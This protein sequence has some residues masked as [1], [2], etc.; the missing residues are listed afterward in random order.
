[1]PPRKNRTRVGESRHVVGYAGDRKCV[2]GKDDYN[3]KVSYTHGMTRRDAER[4]LRKK[5]G[6][7]DVDRLIF[8]LV[9]VAVMK[10]RCDRFTELPRPKRRGKEGNGK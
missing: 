3:G 4:Y 5:L 1:M 2:Y 10:A 6:S 7:H 9:P 8:E